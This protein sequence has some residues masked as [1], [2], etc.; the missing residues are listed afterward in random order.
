[1]RTAGSITLVLLFPAFAIAAG[2]SLT[3]Y[4]LSRDVIHPGESTTIDVAFSEKVKVSI[5]IV[6]SGGTEIPFYS[7]S[8]VTNPNAKDWNG[9]DENGVQMPAG[10][11]TV[12]V[13][14]SSYADP[15]LTLTDSSKT[16]TI[17]SSGAS[18]DIAT[19]TPSATP[20]SKS[21]STYTPPPSQLSVAVD[22]PQDALL[23]VPLHLSARVTTKSGATDPAAQIT[24]SFGDGS[25]AEGNTVEKVYR[26][27]GTY[28]ITVK[29]A[30]V[31]ASAR[32]EL[33]VTVKA[34]KVHLLPVTGEGITIAND[35][36]ER[37][38]LS[39]WRL[40]SDM[41]SFHIPEGTTILPLASVL[42]PFSITNLPFSLE[43][44]LRYPDGVLAAQVAPT[45]LA[46]E[47]LVQLP[48]S[49]P[50]FNTVQT[51]GYDE[52][53]SAENT[54]ISGTAHEN[55]AVRA[56]AAAT[57]LAA[58]GAALPPDESAPA[59]DTRS[60]SLFRSPWTLGFLS[61]MTLAG[62]AFIFL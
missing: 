55:T 35:S 34:A 58:A 14:A 40:L 21:A 10:M 57:E 45:A 16:I 41:G 48:E 59:A 49:A 46:T 42:F 50:S 53:S 28:L 39:G 60:T 36:D 12:L 51:V 33:V 31:S 43:A 32:D 61:L 8:G 9:T 26:Y 13:T 3:T 47:A 4:T 24:W 22:G 17:T 11:Y 37:L 20:A 52:T 19:S 7:S 30:D 18:S 62:G 5:K 38:D 15:G 2:I 44:S 1:M 23:E 25:S 27:T 29:A 6:S 56:P 54:S